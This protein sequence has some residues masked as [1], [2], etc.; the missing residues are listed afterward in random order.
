M[1][2]AEVI[3]HKSASFWVASLR[4]DYKICRDL[5]RLRG[6]VGGGLDIR[7]ST[8]TFNNRSDPDELFSSSFFFV[9]PSGLK[10]M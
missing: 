1:K 8:V 5:I 10:L 4:E 7:V 2:I 6:A 9:T 3:Q